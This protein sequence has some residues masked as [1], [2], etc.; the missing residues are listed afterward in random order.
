MA[1]A[2]PLTLHAPITHCPP[3]TLN[4]LVPSAAHWKFQDP[5]ESTCSVLRREPSYR[6]RILVCVSDSETGELSSLK[7]HEKTPLGRRRTG[8]SS[9]GGGGRPGDLT[10]GHG[11]GLCFY[12]LGSYRTGWHLRVTQPSAAAAFCGQLSGWDFPPL[13]LSSSTEGEIQGEENSGG[14][15]VEETVTSCPGAGSGARPLPGL[16]W[17]W[18]LWPR[19]LTGGSEQPQAWHVEA[20]L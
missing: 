18:D 19:A 5:P 12:L 11:S 4:V 3:G 20:V 8:T 17:R 13:S 1:G 16:H 14:G 9:P 10:R 7:L 2:L 15:D 6:S